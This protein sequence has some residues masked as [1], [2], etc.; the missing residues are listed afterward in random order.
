MIRRR[1]VGISAWTDSPGPVLL[2]PALLSSSGALPPCRHPAA[3]GTH[4]DT[5]AE[6]VPGEGVC[7][8]KYYS[9]TARVNHDFTL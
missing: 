5:G 1:P 3:R 6:L 8:L 9:S 2:E 4:F 7:A